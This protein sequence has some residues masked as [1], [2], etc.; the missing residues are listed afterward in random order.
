MIDD[1][2]YCIDIL[3]QL[4]AAKNSIKSVEAKILKTHLKECV[5]ETLAE[6]SDF[7]TKVEEILKVLKR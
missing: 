4:K 7:D 3:D 2:K 1:G 5:Q 6:K